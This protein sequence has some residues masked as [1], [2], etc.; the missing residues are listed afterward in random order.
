MTTLIMPPAAGEKPNPT[1]TKDQM[2]L[3]PGL[4]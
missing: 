1:L 4:D 3:D 2:R